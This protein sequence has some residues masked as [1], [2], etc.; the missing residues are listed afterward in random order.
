MSK[1]TVIAIAAAFGVGILA[2]IVLLAV[3]LSRVRRR[4]EAF[5]EKARND[6]P[7][8]ARM[9]ELYPHAEARFNDGNRAGRRGAFAPIVQTFT[10]S[11]KLEGGYELNLYRG[12]GPDGISIAEGAYGI[13]APAGRTADLTDAEFDALLEAKGDLGVLTPKIWNRPRLPTK[14]L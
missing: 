6:D 9:Y 10:L 5:V 7:R 14:N 3:F 11:A 12:I 2:F 1:R 13:T 8:V 4:Q